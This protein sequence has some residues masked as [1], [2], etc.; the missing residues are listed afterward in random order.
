MEAAAHRERDLDRLC[1]NTMK[2]SPKAVLTIM[3]LPGL[4]RH[5]PL[6]RLVLLLQLAQALLL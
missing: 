4:D 6:P 1:Q 5:Q 3:P 2:L